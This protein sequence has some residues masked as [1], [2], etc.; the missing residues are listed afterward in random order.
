MRTQRISI[1]CLFVFVILAVYPTVIVHGQVQRTSLDKPGGF[2][3]LLRNLTDQMNFHAGAPLT[4]NPNAV[5]APELTQARQLIAT[6]A[7]DA[8]RLISALNI[9]QR[10]SDQ[11]R[12]LLGDAALLKANSDVLAQRS[13]SMTTIQQF[14]DEYAA[15]D[16]QWRPLSQQ[17]KQLP[18]VGARVVQEVDRLRET[19]KALT[20][21]L[22]LEPQMQR[23]E[24]TYHFAALRADL[25]HLAEDI[26]I[27]LFAD[28]NRVELTN[29]VRTL[30]SRAAQLSAAVDANY[31]YTDV[32]RY[33]KQFF[34]EW[35]ATKRLLRA[36]DNRY[37]QRNINRLT[38]TNQRLHEL[39]WMPPI[40]DGADIL[41]LADSLKFNVD[42]ICEEISLA[43]LMTLPNSTSIF[44]GAQEFYSLCG[45][46]R[47]NV[48][49]S[50]ELE[51]V[52]W[53]FQ[54]LDVSWNDLRN[55]INPLNDPTAAQ[56]IAM[57]DT[58][59]MELRQSLG[60]QSSVDPNEMLQLVSNLT[61]MTDLLYYDLNRY[62]G[63]SNRYPANFRSQA[64][65]SS[66]NLQKIAKAL[67]QSV[68]D[69]R[70]DGQIR[71]Q[72]NDLSAQ[73]NDLQQFLAKVPESDRAQIARSAQQIGPALAKLQI[74]YY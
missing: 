60:Q 9:E 28:P 48:A 27:D 12:V 38:Q 51:S 7:N 31:R 44:N 11:V 42:H 46:F 32:K 8:G 5:V 52:R 10:Y 74:M 16:R 24:V 41:Y 56:Y 72:T 26:Q 65:N 47:Q 58:S 13:R 37:V 2:D 17:L 57:I 33:Y 1:I 4:A 3:G 68:I 64:V 73:W 53:D 35:M 49:K 69:R 63:Q 21:S 6:F 14:A 54:E 61:N 66:N 39:L 23:D 22:Q 50:T 45:T 36:V 30:Q 18:N 29:R 59:V 70:S 15:I 19:S 34:E 20:K 43:K 25:E 71:Q 55:L 40:V 67:Y 62:V